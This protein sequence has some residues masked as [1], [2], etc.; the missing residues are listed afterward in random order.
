MASSDRREERLRVELLPWLAAVSILA[1]HPSIAPVSSS[2]FIL[3]LFALSWV[4]SGAAKSWSESP[5]RL[6]CQLVSL[7]SSTI[8]GSAA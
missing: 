7:P 2:D 3:P 4:A 5:S 6:N 1:A 8:T